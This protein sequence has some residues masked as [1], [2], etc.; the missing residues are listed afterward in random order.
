MEYISTIK[1]IQK[2]IVDIGRIF[3][4]LCRRLEVASANCDSEDRDLP[5]ETRQT[6]ERR[7]E[8]ELNVKAAVFGHLAAA[9]PRQLEIW[10]RRC[11][12]NQR[13][14][15]QHGLSW[16]LSNRRRTTFNH[17]RTHLAQR[18]VLYMVA[19]PQRYCFCDFRFDSTEPRW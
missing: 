16:H 4:S 17:L 10:L 12:P 18:N 5:K 8:N 13:N 3:T 15:S 2:V 1:L 9:S 7:K 19:K 11:F 6:E 14:I